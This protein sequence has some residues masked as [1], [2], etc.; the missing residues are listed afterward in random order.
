MHSTPL[1]HWILRT[2][3][4]KRS[5]FSVLFLLFFFLIHAQTLK[6]SGK[7]VNEKNDPLAGVSVKI[8]GAAGGTTSD[9]EG[10]YTLNLNPEKK[11][12]LEFTAIGYNTKVV[13]DIQAIKG[14]VNE[15]NL[16]LDIQTKDLGGVTVTANRSNGRRETVNALISFQKNTNTV[17]SVI[18]SESIRRSPDKNTGEVLKRIP[19]TSIQD[20]KYIIVRG[21]SDRYNQALLNGIQLSSTEPD[22]KAF[23]F[24]LFPAAMIDNI[25]INKAFVPEYPGEWAGGLIQVNTKDIPSENFLSVQLGT[26]FNSQTIG[27]KFYTYEGGKLDWLGIEDGS[28]AL[29]KGF[30]LKSAFNKASNEEKIELGKQIATNWSVNEGSLPLNTSFQLSGGF[31]AKILKKDVGGILAL[32]Y[33]RS[34]RR[35]QYENHYY[36]I[37]RGATDAPLNFDYYNNKYSQDVLA[38]LLGNITVK[39]N[40]NNRISFKNFLNINTS[41]FVNLRTGKDYES[42]SQEGENIRARELSFKKNTFFNT[43]LSGEH[44]LVFDKF[45]TKLNWFGSFNILDQY[46]PQ[47]RRVQYNQDPTPGAPYTLLIGAALSQK[48]GSVF[49]SNLSD[50][51]YNTGGDITTPFN[52]FN[53]KQNV[54]FGYLFQ[55]KDRLYNARPF[56]VTLPTDNPALRLLSEDDVFNPPNFSDGSETN[57][58]FFDEYSDKRFRYMANTILNAG[59]VQFDNQLNKWLRIVWGVRYEHFDQLVGSIKQSDD[60]HSH[61]VVADFLPAFNATFKLNNK[62]N[63]RASASQTIV[64]P[65]FRELSDLAFYDFELGATVIGNKNLQRTKITNFDLRY[66]LYPR[67]GEIFSLGAFYKYFQNPIEQYYNFGAGSSST[68]NFLNVDKAVGYGVEFEMRKK[69]DFTQ[70]LKNFTFQTNL[71]YIFNRVKDA[72][73]QINRPMQGQSPYVINASLQYD[74]EKSGISTTL[75]F[76]QIGRRIL[77]VGNDQ[78]PD[79]WE[80]PRPLFDFQVAKKFAKNKA[81]VRFNVADIFNQRAVYYHDQDENGYYKSSSTDK[82]AINRNYGTNYSV[83]IGYTIK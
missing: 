15:L 57:Q 62:T 55:V 8:I 10:R 63:F 35:L 81:E 54:K 34:N 83:T 28:R 53:N 27:N 3:L 36:N 78:I 30:P 56:S 70:A 19:G 9:I 23:S 82:I 59:Y 74:L 68:F 2:G 51:I 1:I 12:E 16:V 41:D 64:R 33:N 20:G 37:L 61:S 22:R 38:G 75:L 44:N 69:F 32:T 72:S 42:N 77:Y 80:A 7:I 18:S 79:I 21:L 40:N 50:Y 60:R 4:F 31:N 49:Y 43:Q 6:L 39:L 71:S 65:E 5:F 25:I 24:D 14:Q 11:Y 26:G 48:T 66:E 29:S 58:F 17:A 45:K 76:N 47:Q 13:S 67:A 73:V 52:L 46:V